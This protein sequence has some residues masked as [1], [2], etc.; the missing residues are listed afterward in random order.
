MPIQPNT[1]HEQ[2][3]AAG[4][5]NRLLILFVREVNVLSRQVVVIEKC[6]AHIGLKASRVI[7]G[8]A[9]VFIHIERLYFRKIEPYSG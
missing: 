5:A 2:I 6:P 4:R 1:Q 7:S 8:K 3:D 9:D